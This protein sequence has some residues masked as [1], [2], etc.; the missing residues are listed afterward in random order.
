MSKE[1]ASKR[2]LG[3]GLDGLLPPAPP[4]SAPS[5]ERPIT[6][7]RIEQLHRSQVQPRKRF[8]EEALDELAESIRAHGVLEPILVRKRPAGGYEIIAGERRW[9]AAQKA[10][11][12]E[13]PIFVRELSDESAFEAALVENL[14]R[15]DLNPIE[16]ARA[17]KRLRDE[18][19]LSAD[20]IAVKIGKSRSAVANSMRLLELP[21]AVLDLLEDGALSEG[22][23]RAVLQ[24]KSPELQIKL[25]REA[26]AKKLTVREVE[27]RARDEGGSGKK[28]APAEPK[29]KSP[30]VLDL[31]RRLSLAIGFEVRVEERGGGKGVLEIPW[32]DLDELDRII[33]RLER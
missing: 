18:F 31:E 24:A 9:R 4:S 16:T 3:R 2:R 10:G 19:G 21:E 32:S 13:V 8:D 27:R 6:V 28:G 17:F 33:A 1:Q 29:K 7:A 12:F 25:A 22:H 15:E 14:Q 26:V 5:A 30:N 20:A 11:L 23:G